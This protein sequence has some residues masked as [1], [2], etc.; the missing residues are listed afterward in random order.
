LS[1]EL[2]DFYKRSAFENDPPHRNAFRGDGC[3]E[4][5]R[6]N[7]SLVTHPPSLCGC[8]GRNC[9][10]PETIECRDGISV[11]YMQHNKF[12]FR[13][14]GQIQGGLEGFE[15]MLLAVKYSFSSPCFF[16]RLAEDR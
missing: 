14:A 11:D 7:P 16:V 2:A 6:F 3:Q 10:Q 9:Q 4:L 15:N 5:P 12:R 1:S 13:A 8:I